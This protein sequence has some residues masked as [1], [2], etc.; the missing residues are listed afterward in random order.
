MRQRLAE[1]L[2]THPEIVNVGIA[3][4]T[5]IFV[6]SLALCVAPGVD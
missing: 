6:G 4:L 1:L 5:L 3:I 2:W